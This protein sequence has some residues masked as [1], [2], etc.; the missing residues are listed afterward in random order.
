[1][2]QQLKKLQVKYQNV[3]RNFLFFFFAFFLLK[4]VRI[5]F[6]SSSSDFIILSHLIDKSSITLAKY[7]LFPQ[8]HVTGFQT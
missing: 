2:L 6:V 1:M 3:F 5:V 4:F 7:V 8:L